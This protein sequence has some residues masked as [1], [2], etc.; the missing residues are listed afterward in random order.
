MRVGAE[1]PQL[2]R[3]VLRRH[4]NLARR[5]AARRGRGP[6]LARRRAPARLRPARFE[7]F[8]WRTGVPKGHASAAIATVETLELEGGYFLLAEDREAFEAAEDPDRDGVDILLRWACYTM[9]HPRRLGTFRASGRARS[10]LHVRRGRPRPGAGRWDGCRGVGGAVLRKAHGGP[11]KH[12]RAPRRAVEKG[13]EE[14]FGEVAAFLGARGVSFSC[15]RLWRERLHP[16]RP[17]AAIKS[18]GER[19]QRRGGRGVRA[20][21]SHGGA[22]DTAPPR[23]EDAPQEQEEQKDLRPAGDPPHRRPLP[24]LPP[25]HPH[26]PGQ[27]RAGTRVQHPGSPQVPPGYPEVHSLDW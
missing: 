17:E 5:R 15:S 9:G 18:G 11:A 4:A 24:A 20:L 3:A 21:R 13:V 12:V 22:A 16:P 26:R 8:R 6:L 27:Q 14:R 10:G 7:N 2:Q 23:P 19:H 1:G 25:P